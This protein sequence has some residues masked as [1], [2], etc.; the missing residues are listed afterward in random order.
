MQS[1]RETC[2][3]L[4]HLVFH[5]YRIEGYTLLSGHKRLYTGVHTMCMCISFHGWCDMFVSWDNLQ[6]L[7]SQLE[8][9]RRDGCLISGMLCFFFFSCFS[10]WSVECV[11]VHVGGWGKVA[12]DVMAALVR[13]AWMLNHAGTVH[14]HSHGQKHRG[15]QKPS[16]LPLFTHT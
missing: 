6:L 15:Q 12:K 4:S 5:R 10:S 1:M 11:C 8:Q 9:A 7:F 16:C 14:A 2:V 3:F 13:Q